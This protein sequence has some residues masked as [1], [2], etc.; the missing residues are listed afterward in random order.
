MSAIPES[1]CTGPSW[2][3]SASRRRSSCSAVTIC[4]ESRA[5]SASR[6]CAS[7][8]SRAF[9]L[10]RAAKSAS[11]V[12]RATSAR[13]NGRARTRCSAPICSSRTRSGTRIPWRPFVG[14]AG[15]SSGREQLRPSRVEQ[16]LR[17]EP[18]L[19]EHR[20]RARPAPRSRASTRSAPRG[21]S[22][23][24]R[25]PPRSRGAGRAARGSGTPRRARARDDRREQPQPR[26]ASR[27]ELA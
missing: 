27:P 22:P 18:R 2:R 9:S 12:A 23:A 15:C 24:P 5:R 26:R 6:T 17:L 7:S 19:L 16:V 8:S 11:T 20:C 13:A 25:A 21:S 4:S 3:K 14:L 10:S 1:D